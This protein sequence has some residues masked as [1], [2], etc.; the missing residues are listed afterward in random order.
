MGTK[1][2]II[3]IWIKDGNNIIIESYEQIIQALQY[4]ILFYKSATVT[5]S[6]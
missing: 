2:L 4:H 6:K 1:L 3:S 5:I